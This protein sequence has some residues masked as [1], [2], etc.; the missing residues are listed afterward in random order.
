M[1]EAPAAT[2]DLASKREF[3]GVLKTVETFYVGVFN[4]II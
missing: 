2:E 4:E 3:C 1:T